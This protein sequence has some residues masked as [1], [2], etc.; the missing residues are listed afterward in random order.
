MMIN[1]PIY[2]YQN[3]KELNF[4]QKKEPEKPRDK[5]K[6]VGKNGM[7]IVERLTQE[8]EFIDRMIDV[9]NLANSVLQADPQSGKRV[10]VKREIVQEYSDTEIIGWI[11]KGDDMEI[12]K[13]PYFY[14]A[15]CEEAKARLD[16]IYANK[17]K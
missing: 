17:K 6:E 7:G 14:K 16:R 5:E 9:L 12:R 4:K 2:Q 13:N 3:K 15:I 8:K 10:A 1:P 11:D